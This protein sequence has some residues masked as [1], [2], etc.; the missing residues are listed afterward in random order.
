LKEEIAH[1]MANLWATNTLHFHLNKLF[2]NMVCILVLFGLPTVLATFSKMGDF[3]HVS[4]HPGRQL[5]DSTRV[6]SRLTL[7]G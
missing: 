1:K 5:P 2:K 7:K 6:G 4:G 3:F